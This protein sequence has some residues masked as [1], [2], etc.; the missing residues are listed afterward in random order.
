MRIGARADA[1]VLGTAQACRSVRDLLNPRL[2]VWDV[3][4]NQSPPPQDR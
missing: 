3:Q 2:D 4:A 1:S